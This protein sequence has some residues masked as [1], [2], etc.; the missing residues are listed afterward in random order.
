MEFIRAMKDLVADDWPAFVYIL[1]ATGFSIR[2]LQERRAEAQ[3]VRQIGE[4]LRSEIT[5]RLDRIEDSLR[6]RDGPE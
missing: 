2:F 3:M 4:N 6:R 5:S 1:I